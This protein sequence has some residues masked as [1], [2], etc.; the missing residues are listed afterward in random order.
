MYVVLKEVSVP[1]DLSDYLNAFGLD[2]TTF[3]S[4][5]M[6]LSAT[7]HSSQCCL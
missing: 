4:G 7:L 3:K 2:V 1:L 6:K 5:R